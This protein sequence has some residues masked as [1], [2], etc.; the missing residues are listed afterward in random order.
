MAGRALTIDEVTIGDESPAWVIAEIGH[1]HQGDLAKARRLFQEARA[2]GAAA[3][4]LQKRHNRTLFTREAYDKPYE[5]V[6][7]FGRTYGEHR[8]F[9]E[10]G[11]DEYRALQEHAAELGVTFFATAFDFRSADFLAELDMPAYKLASGDLRNV[12]LLVHVARIGKPMIVSTGGATLDDVRRAHDAVMPINRQLAILQCTAA[13]PTPF[14][15]LDLNVIRTY[16]DSFPD[17]VI[18]LSAH[19]DST[20]TAVAAYALGA[21]ILEKHFTLDRVM[22]GTDHAFSLDPAGLRTMVRDLTQV[23]AAL[24]DSIKKCHA[25]EGPG[26]TKMSKKLVAAR[27]LAPGEILTADVVALKSPGDGLPPYE[28]PNVLGRRLEKPLDTD[29]AIRLDMLGP[30]AR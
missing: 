2:A 13:Y 6:N 29:E 30:R 8:E 20:A 23:H 1:N 12:P 21:R 9:L 26:I 4:K 27:P 11:R 10:F 3:V 25:S 16:R 15:E 19:D 24:G 7:S 17:V 22:R 14:H 5:H 18:G 28:L